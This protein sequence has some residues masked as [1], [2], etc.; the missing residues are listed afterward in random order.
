MGGRARDRQRWEHKS[1][2]AMRVLGLPRVTGRFAVYPSREHVA[3][4][5][6]NRTAELYRVCDGVGVLHRVHI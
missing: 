3:H 5:E 1:V 2:Q 6:S 4:P